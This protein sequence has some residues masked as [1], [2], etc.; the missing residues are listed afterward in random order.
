[1]HSL[2]HHL[3]A[4]WSIGLWAIAA[5]LAAQ[6]LPLGPRPRPQ[7]AREE[8]RRVVYPAEFFAAFA[9]QTVLDILARTPGFSLEIGEEARGFGANAGN[10]LIDGQR[11]TVKSGGIETVL[12]RI[13]A[14]RVERV[15]L[16]RSAGTADAAGRALIAN[17]VLLASTAVSGTVSLELRH[18]PGDS[19]ITPRIEVSYS[20]PV[21]AWQ[22]SAGFL[23]WYENNPDRG[24]Y[25]LFDA[26][27]GPSAELDE[28]LHERN[29]GGTL[30]ASASGAFAGGS[31]NLNGRLAR[32]HETY[33]Q[34]VSTAMASDDISAVLGDY[35]EWDGELGADW[36]QAL[37]R[38]W[39]AKLV[40]LARAERVR[41]GEQARFAA[42]EDAFLQRNLTIEQVARATVQRQGN[43]RL[44][45]EIGGE[46]AWNRLRSRFRS[47]IDGLADRR[48]VAERRLDLFGNA[49]LRLSKSL[50]L[51][52]GIG[53]ESSRIVVDGGDGPSRTLSFWK[54]S[55][56]LA[57][58]VGRRTQARIALRQTVGQLDFEGFAASGNLIDNRP[59]TGNA[60][61]RPE[62]TTAWTVT[63]DHRFGEAG[64]ALSLTL[65]H[66]TIEE[67][68]AYVPLSYGGQALANFGT[69][70]L[71][72]A[73]GKATLPLDTLL[74]GAQL[75][76][77][78]E[79]VRARRPD[80]L[81]GRPRSDPRDQ[82]RWEIAWRHDLTTLRAAYGVSVTYTGPEREW[83]VDEYQ[84]ERYR[85]YVTAY[86]EA[87]M[88]ARMKATLT[89]SGLTGDWRFRKRQFHPQGQTPA[90]HSTEVRRRMRGSYVN[91]L[92]TRQF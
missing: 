30:T 62:V 3:H 56:A 29:R 55:A 81:T 47:G 14:S 17:V 34:A 35:R 80:P 82:D 75:T 2:K 73:I 89:A 88:P 21:A 52:A 15:E 91:L 44:A 19:E 10:V 23:G 78:G 32:E 66:E 4:A 46:I 12:A 37:G 38:G 61:L 67:A 60:D 48:D 43:H 65:A 33:R 51:E 11:P 28:R 13:A 64:G 63:A 42:G 20:W 26:A 25:R 85:P 31:L 68:L 24:L 49:T 87:Q 58:D 39:T 79:W 86:V 54:P 83:Y 50:R 9:P 77:E 53:F 84:H 5:P 74:R 27:G 22:A 1:V 7:S 72:R 76:I 92:L 57:W 16:I 59:I 41:F 70:K 71:W 8:S 69:V 36:T 90:S 6:D 45:P 40:G 18:A